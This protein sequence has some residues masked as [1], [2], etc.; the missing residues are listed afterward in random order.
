MQ[1]GTI[2]ILAYKF[3]DLQNIHSYSVGLPKRHFPPPE[4]AVVCYQRGL[5]RL[6]LLKICFSQAKP[7]MESIIYLPPNTDTTFYVQV[8]RRG[9]FTVK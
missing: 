9:S 3:F 5:P 7:V 4:T 6:V 8:S 2:S 1:E